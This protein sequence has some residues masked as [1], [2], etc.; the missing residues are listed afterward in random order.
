MKKE[1]VPI[2]ILHGWKLQGATYAAFINLLKKDGYKVYSWDLPGFGKE[3]P[4]SESLTLLDYAEFVLE[5]M[6]KEHLG[7]AIFIGHSFGGR[8]ALKIAN[9]YPEKVKKLILTGV[10]II[11]N[12]SFKKKTQYA[13]AKIGKSAFSFFPE[14]TKNLFR[15]TFYRGIGE[16]DYYKAGNLKK[17]LQNILSEDVLPYFDQTSVP[18]V[19]VWGDQDS[20]VPVSILKKLQKIKPQAEYVT[21]SGMKHSPLRDNPKEYYKAI[22]TFL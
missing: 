22:Q 13:V 15:K 8:V 16:M 14:N 2:I 4:S 17:T 5:K 6:K 3:A 20:F 10:P 7:K 12:T 18:V 19:L 11:R 21:L 9:L 1:K